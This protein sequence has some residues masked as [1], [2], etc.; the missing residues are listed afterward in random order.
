MSEARVDQ[1]ETPGSVDGTF[2]GSTVVSLVF[3]QIL[4]AVHNGRLQPGERISDSELAERLGVSRTPVR[5]ALQRLREI[6]II[7]ASASRFTRIA[8]VSPEQT[9]N[10]MV[11]WLAL[12]A[13][14]IT[15]V[16]P[17]VSPEVV[18]AMRAD[19]ENFVSLLTT[20]DMQRIATAN[21]EFF[22]HLV[23]LSRNPVLRRGIQSVV[24]VVRLGSLHLPDQIDFRALSE[25]QALLVAAARDHDRAAALGALRMLGTIRVPTDWDDTPK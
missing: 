17:T 3:N 16:I 19:H 1:T 20:G 7:E 14:V 22:N 13:A 15:E 21:A 24:H 12:Y 23:E 2:I 5:E 11:V 18:A 6:G 4:D 10:A 25:S 9:A 8:V